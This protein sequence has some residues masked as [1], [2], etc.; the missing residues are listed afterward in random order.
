MIAISKVPGGG[1][2]A[3]KLKAWCCSLQTLVFAAIEGRAWKTGGAFTA[4]L[5]RAVLASVG[6]IRTVDL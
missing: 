4:L 6:A 2:G 3:C 5:G 1:E